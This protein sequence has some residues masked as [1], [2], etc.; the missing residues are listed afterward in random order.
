[1]K[2]SILLLSA[3]FLLL[4]V[5]MAQIVSEN[6]YQEEWNKV[7]A[8]EDGNLPR[9]IIESVDSIFQKAIKEENTPQVIK[10]LLY[11]NKAKQRI[12]RDDNIQIFSDL[13]SLLIKAE[14]KSDRALLY[15]MLAELY[16]NYYY[17]NRWT[18]DHRT[19]LE[20]TPEDM[21]TWSKNNVYDKVIECLNQSV[22]DAETLKGYT[23]KEYEDIIFMGISAPEYYP[24]MY[25]FLMYRAIAIL[26]K[27]EVYQADYRKYDEPHTWELLSVSAKEFVKIDIDRDNKYIIFRYYQQYLKDLLSR[28]MIPSIIHTEMDKIEYMSGLKSNQIKDKEI[29]FAERL[30]DE[31]KENESAL[32]LIL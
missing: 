13:K 14:S 15:S 3:L 29:A 4:N 9:S 17:E 12:D 10:A 2:K 22:A 26:R 19:N 28:N 11:K 20:Y 24:T 1:M 5:G 18:I 32:E 21:K 31:Y 30:F 27:H 6:K 16:G 7:Y 8:L 25:D 23:T